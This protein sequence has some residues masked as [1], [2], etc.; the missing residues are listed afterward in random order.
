MTRLRLVKALADKLGPTDVEQ[1]PTGVNTCDL[2]HFDQLDEVGKL[3]VAR[4][5]METPEVGKDNP[6]SKEL[7]RRGY[8]PPEGEA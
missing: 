8:G 2:E 3:C 1:E 7:R 6:I 5:F 4:A